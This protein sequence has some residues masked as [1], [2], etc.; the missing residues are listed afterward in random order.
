MKNNRASSPRAFHSAATKCCLWSPVI[1]CI[2]GPW[3]SQATWKRLI[4]STNSGS[5]QQQHGIAVCPAAGIPG[6]AN[7]QVWRQKMEKAEKA[8][9]HLLITPG[10]PKPRTAWVATSSVVVTGQW[11]ERVQ[12]GSWHPPRRNSAFSLRAVRK[13]I[14]KVTKEI[15]EYPPRVSQQST[16]VRIL[17]SC[18]PPSSVFHLSYSVHQGS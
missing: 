10:S 14:P 18:P 6:L 5:T 7:R 13:E 12:W 15:R 4:M 16:R 2:A 9:S 11:L 1:S 8:R 3:Q 17:S